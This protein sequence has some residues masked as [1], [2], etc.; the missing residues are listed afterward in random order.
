MTVSSQRLVRNYLALYPK[1]PIDKLCTHPDFKQKIGE[2]AKFWIH[3][4]G[5]F[6]AESLELSSLRELKKKVSLIQKETLEVYVACERLQFDHWIKHTLSQASYYGGDDIGQIRQVRLSSLAHLPLPLGYLASIQGS[7]QEDTAVFQHIQEQDRLSQSLL[8]TKCQGGPYDFSLLT[9]SEKE[10]LEPYLFSKASLIWDKKYYNWYQMVR[11]WL[12]L[13]GGSY[14]DLLDRHLPLKPLLIHQNDAALQEDLSRKIEKEKPFFMRLSLQDL[15]VELTLRSLSES[16]KVQFSSPLKNKLTAD[17]KVDEVLRQKTLLSAYQLVKE[18]LDPLSKSL[19]MFI[20]LRNKLTNN[21]AKEGTPFEYDQLLGWIYLSDMQLRGLQWDRCSPGQMRFAFDIVKEWE[22]RRGLTVEECFF[23][24]Q[25]AV[26]TEDFTLLIQH[27]NYAEKVCRLFYPTP[28][29]LIDI[30]QMETRGSLKEGFESIMQL[31]SWIKA[32]LLEDAEVPSLLWKLPF[33]VRGTLQKILWL[34][35]LFADLGPSPSLQQPIHFQGL[36]SLLESPEEPGYFFQQTKSYFPLSFNEKITVAYRLLQLRKEERQRLIFE[37]ERALSLLS[38]ESMMGGEFLKCLFF[39]LIKLSPQE[40]H[41]QLNCLEQIEMMIGE[42][43]SPINRYVW[44]AFCPDLNHVTPI[45]GE[46]TES[47]HDIGSM[48]NEESLHQDKLESLYTNLGRLIETPPSQ[49]NNKST[50]REFFS[51]LKQTS[52][53]KMLPEW[54]SLISSGLDFAAYTLFA[55]VMTL[56]TYSIFPMGGH[57]WFAEFFSQLAPLNTPFIIGEEDK[58]EVINAAFYP[59]L[60]PRPDWRGIHREWKV[61]LNEED[62]PLF[63]LSF[64][65]FKTGIAPIIEERLP[66]SWRAFQEEPT[67]FSLL[68]DIALVK[69]SEMEG[70]PLKEEILNSPHYLPFKRAVSQLKKK[71]RSALFQ[72]NPYF[73]QAIPALHPPIINLQDNPL[74][75]VW[76]EMVK[77]VGDYFFREFKEEEEPSQKSWIIQEEGRVTL[78]CSWDHFTPSPIRKQ[79]DPISYIEMVMQCENSL[80]RVLYPQDLLRKK[81]FELIQW[82]LLL[83]YHEMYLIDDGF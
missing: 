18:S 15:V 65:D 2:V 51:S 20:Q 21:L 68:Q 43:L 46:F 30:L 38:S 25:L 39:H 74:P 44:L 54:E 79:G 62:P 31:D 76:Q 27:M 59:L 5:F 49:K 57:L 42:K 35:E 50:R 1:S 23:V 28:S 36:I 73:H 60:D 14:Q 37:V 4:F 64:L 48:M 40:I 7:T 81:P 70:A 17:F 12:S 77:A 11:L 75:S 3:A 10:L 67:L 33:K 9:P 66:L 82:Q 83:L 80:Q 53:N 24:F 19:E 22:V 26:Y 8:L 45:I 6:Y 16:W 63:R 13:K 41:L 58:K 52:L 72:L 69:G 55:E 71:L 61:P 34:K 29:F 32:F 47:C 56:L 78:S